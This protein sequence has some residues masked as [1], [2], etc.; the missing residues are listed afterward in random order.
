MVSIEE[1]MEYQMNIYI[2]ERYEY[3]YEFDTY[4]YNDED[5]HDEYIDNLRMN[6]FNSDFDFGDQMIEIF[7]DKDYVKILVDVCK[8]FRDK[9]DTIVPIEE[10]LEKEKIYGKYAYILSY[11]D[12]IKWGKIEED[13]LVALYGCK[14]NYLMGI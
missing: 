4:R 1:Q 5:R 7:S 9:Y 2:Q 13:D 6:F 11:N 12:N 8:Y 14:I 3:G 10:Y